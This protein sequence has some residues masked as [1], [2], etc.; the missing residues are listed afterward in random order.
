M[1]AASKEDLDKLRK[2]IEDLTNA[3]SSGNASI[4]FKIMVEAVQ[5]GSN[6]FQ[7]TTSTAN[8]A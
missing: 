6:R 5:G 1:A 8:A 2:A 7:Q 4:S 3:I